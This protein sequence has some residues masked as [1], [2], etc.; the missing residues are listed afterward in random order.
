M[1]PAVKDDEQIDRSVAA[2]DRTLSLLEAFL[3]QPGARSLSDL[4]QRTGLFKSVILRYML[5]LEARGFVHK[6]QNGMYRLG[7]KAAQLGRAFESSVDLVTTL[8]P[9]VER[10]SEK[11]GSSASVYV[12]DGESRLCLLRAE[13]ERDVRVAIRAGTRRPMDKSASSL[14]FRRFERKTVQAFATAGEWVF[15][16][17]VYPQA[18]IWPFLVRGKRMKQAYAAIGRAGDADVPSG[19]SCRSRKASR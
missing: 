19:F 3:D 7:Y 11:T 6:E 16:L 9:V 18:E 15:L 10:L 12:R 14:A 4:E 8:R 13:P 5:S 2:V 17:V 1:K